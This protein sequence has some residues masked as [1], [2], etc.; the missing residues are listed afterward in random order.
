MRALRV[1]D[2]VAVGP[3]PRFSDVFFFTHRDPDAA[4]SFVR[5]RARS[6]EVLRLSPGHYL[7]V[8]GGL[9]AAAEVRKGDWL[10]LA[11]G[12]A[13]EV[14]EVGDVERRGLFKPQTLHG[15]IVV[16]GV[17]NSTYTTAVER[18]LAHGALRVLRWCYRSVPGVLTRGMLGE[19]FAEGSAALAAVLRA[20][21][22]GVGVEL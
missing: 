16:D 9:K 1:G 10:R 17:V 3:G 7:Y 6:G 15:D 22:R 20:D 19:A 14:A 13:A 4:A 8:A 21:G 5:I 12:E 2:R 11:S 18:R